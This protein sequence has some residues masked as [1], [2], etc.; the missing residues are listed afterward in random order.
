MKRAGL[1]PALIFCAGLQERVFRR[2][3]RAVQLPS[4]EQRSKR[5]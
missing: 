3:G 4:D 2:P 5:P 1:K